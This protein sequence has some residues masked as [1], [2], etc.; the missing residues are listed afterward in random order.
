[1]K[2][3]SASVRDIQWQ[4]PFTPPS[5]ELPPPGQPM[6]VAREILKRLYTLPAGEIIRAHRGD[7]YRWNGQCWP[8]VEDRDVRAQVYGLLEHATY[9]HPEKEES[10]PFAPT[11]HKVA[12]VLDALKAIVLQPSATEPPFWIDHR[13]TPPAT[14]VIALTNG[15]LHLPTRTLAPHTTAFF[16]H[17][18]L[19]FAFDPQAPVAERWIT[20]LQELWEDDFATVDALQ[21]VFGYIIAG[22]TR[23]QKMFLLVGPKRGGKGTI[24]RVLTG[25]LGTHHVAAPTLASLSQNFGLQALI[26]K[27]LALISDARLSTRADSKIVVERLLSISGEDSLTIDRKYKEPWTGRLPTRFL[28]LTNELPR[29]SDASGA[30][31]S[32]FILF[33]GTRSFYGAENPYLTDELLTEAPAILNWAL[34]GLDRL[35]ARGYFV[36][37]P[38]G[39]EA[40]QQM[41]DLAAP[42]AAFIR[43][44]CVIDANGEVE[45]DAIWSAWK[46]WCEENNRS[47]GTKDVFGRDLFAAVPTVRKTRPRRDD[48]KDDSKQER[49]HVYVGLRLRQKSDN[50]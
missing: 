6:A 42:V 41:E 31:A 16:N 1:M 18:A 23:Q 12:D 17:H 14:E 35:H 27:P 38:S 47:C 36:N 15:L 4:T 21:E 7:F 22:T 28:V 5:L 48:S 3:K 9:W 19:P 2:K 24:G 26:G 40:L 39:A 37:P 50:S 11:Q 49:K 29:L 8:E 43:Q 10:L 33:V 25:L 13:T 20:F 46:H 30:L 45:V 44:T 34:D 32:R